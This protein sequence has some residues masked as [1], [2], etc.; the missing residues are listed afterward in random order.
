MICANFYK[1]KESICKFKIFGHSGY[2]KAGSDIVCS[3][4]S[5]L[6]DYVLEL[7]ENYFEADIELSVNEK[8]A[9]I[10]CTIC[11]SQNNIEKNAVIQKILESFSNQL[12]AIEK[13]YPKFLSCSLLNDLD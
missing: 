8:D 10:F 3:S 4:V 12:K 11:N 9:A 2:S 1:N 7:L 13:D 5:A 6:T